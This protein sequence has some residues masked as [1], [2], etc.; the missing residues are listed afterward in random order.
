MR[1]LIPHPS[2]RHLDL[3]GNQ[4]TSVSGATF[5]ATLIV[6]SLCSSADCSDDSNSIPC[7]TLT[8]Q[9]QSALNYWGPTATCVAGICNAGYEAPAGGSCTACAPGVLVCLYVCTLQPHIAVCEQVQVQ[10]YVY[11]YNSLLRM[12]YQVIVNVIV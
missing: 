1:S 12:C 7:V 9:Q 10:Q 5:P 2:H 11:L 4:L 6:L 3:R 8:A